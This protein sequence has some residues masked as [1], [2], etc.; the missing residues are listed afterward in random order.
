MK[1]F[2]PAG[3][4]Q[5]VLRRQF[6]RRACLEELPALGAVIQLDS[7]QM[8]VS[9]RPPE[10]HAC[11][12]TPLPQSRLPVKSGFLNKKWRVSVK[13]NTVTLPPFLLYMIPK[14]FFLM[15]QQWVNKAASAVLCAGTAAQKEFLPEGWIVALFFIFFEMDR[16]VLFADAGTGARLLIHC[17]LC[18]FI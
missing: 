10:S 13:P 4:Q 11:H 14:A 7:K 8:G 6:Q 2:Y 9:V 3:F 15:P 12:C 16:W 18:C 5:W 17:W 1:S